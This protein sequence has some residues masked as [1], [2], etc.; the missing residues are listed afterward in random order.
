LINGYYEIDTGLIT[1]AEYQLFIDATDITRRPCHWDNP[2]FSLGM[3]KLPI[4]GVKSDDAVAFCNWLNKQDSS[5]FKYRLPTLTEA[6]QVPIQESTIG[7]WCS[8][9]GNYIIGGI[10]EEQ[11]KTWQSSHA[12]LLDSICAQDLVD[13]LIFL[14]ESIN[15]I[16]IDLI[17]TIDSSRLNSNKYNSNLNRLRARNHSLK[18]IREQVRNSARELVQELKLIQEFANQLKQKCIL[19]QD[20]VFEYLQQIGSQLEH[21]LLFNSDIVLDLDLVRDIDLGLDSNLT[22]DLDLAHYLAIYR[23]RLLLQTRNFAS[24]LVLNLA[25]DL[26]NSLIESQNFRDDLDKIADLD[27]KKVNNLTRELEHA[28]VLTRLQHKQNQKQIEL[29]FDCLKYFLAQNSYVIARYCLLLISA[30]WYWLSRFEYNF[31]NL[32]SKKT[33][34]LQEDYQQQQRQI[35]K[36][37]NSFLLLQERKNGKIPAWEGIR[38]VRFRV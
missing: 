30:C 14:L 8:D 11:W 27:L 33:K 15:D 37:Y 28:L 31:N 6:N 29:A 24:L 25:R 22:A 2:H 4:A 12:N 36:I 3:A 10:T 7:Y 34:S 18:I 20:Y 17:L 26:T 19:E 5:G 9:N 38:L 13:S 21:N 35:L 16:D 23:E 32:S 1:C